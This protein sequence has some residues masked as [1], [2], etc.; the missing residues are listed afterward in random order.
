MLDQ[1]VNYVY[2]IKD[3]N[4][5]NNS[6]CFI[7]SKIK[8]DDMKKLTFY[9]QYKYKSIMPNSVLMKNEIKG[10]LMKCYKVQ[11]ICDVDTDDIINLQENFKN[12]FNKEIGTSIINNFDIYEVKGLIGE[13][14]KIVY[15]TIEMWR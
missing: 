6:G 4:N 11:N 7:K 1:E 13:L 9:I 8:P 12:Y 10:L 5:D 14:R 2:E 15:L 3:N